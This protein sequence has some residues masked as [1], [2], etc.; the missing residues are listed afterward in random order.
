MSDDETMVSTNHQNWIRNRISSLNGSLRLRPSADLPMIAE[1]PM[2]SRVSLRPLFPLPGRI[3]P[4]QSQ[5]EL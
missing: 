5:V 2:P 1:L 3:L 4:I